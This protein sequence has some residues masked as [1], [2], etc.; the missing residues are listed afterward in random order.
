MN[1]SHLRILQ[2]PLSPPEE[3]PTKCTLP[4]ISSL[5]EGVDRMSQ[6]Q[7]ASKNSQRKRNG[8]QRVSEALT[9]LVFQNDIDQIHR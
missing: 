7:E 8:L 3:E 5:L 6:D 2:G 9:S 4:S 1:Y